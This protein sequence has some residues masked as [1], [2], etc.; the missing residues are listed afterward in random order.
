V[1]QETYLKLLER[2]REKGYVFE[3]E[4]LTANNSIVLTGNLMT[5][6]KKQLLNTD[7]N[8]GRIIDF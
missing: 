5:N 1:Q 6:S 3:S 8:E 2:A 4:E 7:I